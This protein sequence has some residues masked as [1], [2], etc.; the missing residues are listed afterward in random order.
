M[1]LLA[2]TLIFAGCKKSD[3]QDSS[4]LVKM[5]ATIYNSGPV[6]ADGCD[7]TIKVGDVS[8]HPDNLTEDLKIT[9]Q[10]VIIDAQILDQQFICG[11]AAKLTYLHLNSV[12]KQ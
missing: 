2:G 6:A 7:W 3:K 1:L 5:E 10:K 11:W 8:Y 12:V 4:R 9:G